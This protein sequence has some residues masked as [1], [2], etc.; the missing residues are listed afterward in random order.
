MKTP[1]ASDRRSAAL[2]LGLH[3]Q[4]LYQVLT[5]RRQL[6]GDKCPDVERVLGIPCEQLRPDIR[7]HRV[8]DAAWLWHP[9]GRPCIDLVGPGR[10][11]G[12]ESEAG[13]V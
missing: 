9:A 8:A 1:S 12:S 11:V 3:E 13:S 10:E 6:P 7:W 5:R 4:Y 2:E